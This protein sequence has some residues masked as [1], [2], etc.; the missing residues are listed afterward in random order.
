MA[1]LTRHLWFGDE[2]RRTSIVSAPRRAR[3]NQSSHEAKA[4]TVYNV[5]AAQRAALEMDPTTQRTG[6]LNLQNR[7]AIDAEVAH[8]M[9]QWTS[10]FQRVQHTSALQRQHEQHVYITWYTHLTSTYAT[11]QL[12]AMRLQP[13]PL[14]VLPY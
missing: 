9:N 2:T 7:S 4:G 3:N 13:T 10:V 8:N 12:R 11:V 5:A 14:N 1:I 6:L